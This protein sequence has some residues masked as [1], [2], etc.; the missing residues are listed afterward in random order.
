MISWGVQPCLPFQA[1]GENNFSNELTKNRQ[2]PRDL[3]MK[4]LDQKVDQYMQLS[5]HC[6]QS[7]FIAVK[8][9]FGL[10]GE[11]VIKALTPLPGIAGDLRSHH[12]SVDG[13]GIN[14]WP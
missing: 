8:A 9:Q 14:L 1:S 6:A 2:M 5:H 4:M 3:V 12:R 10:D 13:H 11:Q 7:S